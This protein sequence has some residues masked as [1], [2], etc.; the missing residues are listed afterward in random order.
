MDP[1][2]TDHRWL[3]APPKRYTPSPQDDLAVRPRQV[4]AKRYRL[5]EKLAHGGMGIVWAAEH[6]ALGAPVAVKFLDPRLA[7]CPGWVER[8]AHEARTAAAVVSP[9]VVHILDFGV[10]AGVPYLVMEYLVGETLAERLV[11]DGP[12]DPHETAVLFRGVACAAQSA[13][14]RGIVHLDLKPANVFL[15]DDFGDPF[16]KILDFGIARR[17][18]TWPRREAPPSEELGRQFLGTPCYMSPEQITNTDPLDYRSDLWSLAVL[19]FECLTGT[20]PFRGGDLTDLIAAICVRPAPIPSAVGPVPSGFDAWFL[21]GVER[22]PGRRFESAIA[23]SRALS[24]LC[25]PGQRRLSQ[26]PRSAPPISTEDFLD[27]TKTDAAELPDAFVRA[28]GS[29]RVS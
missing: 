19:A 14:D 9:H 11:R 23:A 29:P 27:T 10:E 16:V 26:A 17:A 3:T 8:F 21:Q 22:L 24:D 7:A 15:V 20:R 13:H 4:L 2:E 12:L 6:V 18:T 25:R 5:A 28:A 1:L